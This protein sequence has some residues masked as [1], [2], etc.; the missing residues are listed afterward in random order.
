VTFAQNYVLRVLPGLLLQ[1]IKY[2]HN[3]APN[4]KGPPKRA[5]RT[6]WC[7]WIPP[8]QTYFIS[9]KSSIP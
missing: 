6:C 3:V 4:K 2:V 5:R 7:Y 9:M 1:A 8:R